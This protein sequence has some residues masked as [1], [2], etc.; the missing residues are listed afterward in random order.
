MKEQSNSYYV[1]RPT[2]KKQ[3]HINCHCIVG[4]QR[5]EINAASVWFENG[6]G[7]EMI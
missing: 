7:E 1:K 5:V 2:K 4:M 6:T 3:T